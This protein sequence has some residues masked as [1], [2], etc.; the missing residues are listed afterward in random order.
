MILFHDEE[1]KI[2]D[3]FPTILLLSYFFK[4]YVSKSL[5]EVLLLSLLSVITY[6]EFPNYGQNF[7]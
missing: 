2:D 6:Q 3:I 7:Q 4:N 1:D 5:L